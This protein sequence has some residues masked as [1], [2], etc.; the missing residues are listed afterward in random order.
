MSNLDL[1][2][3]VEEMFTSRVKE[4][5]LRLTHHLTQGACPD[6]ATYRHVVGHIQG[7]E[8]ALVIFDEIIA[9]WKNQ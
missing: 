7:Y 5:V 4:E 1:P 3:S 9:R 6:H 2:L 8:E